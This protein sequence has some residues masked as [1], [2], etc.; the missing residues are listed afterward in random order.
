MILETEIL[1]G[2]VV[3]LSPDKMSTLDDLDL[4]KCTVLEV[5][6]AEKRIKVVFNNN[7]LQS[8]SFFGK[9]ST[10][11]WFSTRHVIDIERDYQ[12]IKITDNQDT[13]SNQPVTI[14]TMAKVIKAVQ[15]SDKGYTLVGFV[16]KND[17]D[18]FI[19]KGIAY[20]DLIGYLGETKRISFARFGCENVV[21]NGQNAKHG[22]PITE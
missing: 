14:L 18:L 5:D 4:E 9:S 15:Q 22:T 20:N 19:F 21:I 2:D 7:N 3:E 13:L 10:V 6:K 17:T 1:I 8:E 11:S 12:I 16:N